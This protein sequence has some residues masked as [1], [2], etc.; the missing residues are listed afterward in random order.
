[1]KLAVRDYLQSVKR[2]LSP[3]DAYIV[4]MYEEVKS[5]GE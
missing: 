1:M 3:F 2:E 4:Q 5:Y